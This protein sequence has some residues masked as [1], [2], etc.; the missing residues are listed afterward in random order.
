VGVKTMNRSV[1][2][3]ARKGRKDSL[4]EAQKRSEVTATRMFASKETTRQ[5]LMWRARASPPT[6]QQEPRGTQRYDAIAPPHHGVKKIP[7]AIRAGGAVAPHPERKTLVDCFRD[8]PRDGRST[9]R[10][11]A[12]RSDPPATPLATTSRPLAQPANCALPTL[13]Y[14]L[15]HG[16]AM[17][18][19]RVPRASLPS[20]HVK[21]PT[22]EDLEGLNDT[23]MHEPCVAGSYLRLID[24][25]ITQLKA[26]GPSRT[27]NESQEEE[28][29]NEAC[30][31]S[32]MPA[33]YYHPPNHHDDKV[34][35]DQ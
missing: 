6:Q 28:K 5:R 20:L 14:L 26:Q 13:D 18:I 27:C 3:D 2:G 8:S 29:K 35:S 15:A 30:V 21:T 11:S 10:A 9:A 24:S 17:Q 33:R 34:D 19:P 25:C 12:S 31:G 32:K 23:T 22:P 4:Y 1:S 16:T 7:K